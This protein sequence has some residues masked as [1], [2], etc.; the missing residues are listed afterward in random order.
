MLHMISIKLCV[1]YNM[2]VT[3]VLFGLGLYAST[4]NRALKFSNTEESFC[5]TIMNLSISA[6]H[7]YV[8]MI[9]VDVNT[10]NILRLT[11]L[12]ASVQ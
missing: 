8:I 6:Y 4:S 7:N 2:F 1:L 12:M 5:D 11:I 9:F 3:C 10:L